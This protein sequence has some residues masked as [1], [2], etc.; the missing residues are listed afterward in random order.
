LGAFLPW[1]RTT[2]PATG[3]TLRWGMSG[4]RGVIALLLGL[5]VIAIGVLSLLGRRLRGNRISLAGIGILALIFTVVERSL[6]SHDIS[7]LRFKVSSLRNLSA[8][9]S[10]AQL[11]SNSFGVGLAMIGIG[12]VVAIIAGAFLPRQLAPERVTAPSEVP[13]STS[14]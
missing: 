2:I 6:I 8:A 7:D 3:S 14:V 4:G 12:A 9:Q 5:A 11:P 13:A 1:S 10:A